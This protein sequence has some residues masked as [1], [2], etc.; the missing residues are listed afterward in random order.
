M[1]HRAYKQA[2]YREFARIGLALA[3]DRRLEMVDLLAQGPRHVEAL[4]NEAEMSVANASQHLQVL[5]QARLVEA[6]KRGTRVTYRLADDSVLR[7]WL[8]L[9]DVAASRIT[10]V[11]A[12]ARESGAAAT[13]DAI[14]REEFERLGDGQLLLLDVR[15][16]EEFEHGHLKGAVSIPVDELEQRMD[17]L[18]R[19]RPIVAYCRGAYC[20]FAGDAVELL[21][22]RGF[23]AMRLDEG[24]IEWRAQHEAPLAA[25]G[26]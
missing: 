20:L 12:L 11:Q 22:A 15:P 21:R 6:E 2:L 19:D 23:N 1:A 4:A 18:P 25:A 8:A 10:E 13:G 24:W 26:S 17:E 16:R 3:S 9:R 14:S 5:R 7:L